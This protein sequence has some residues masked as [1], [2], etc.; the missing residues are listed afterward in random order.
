MK[1]EELLRKQLVGKKVLLKEVYEGKF[2]LY[3]KKSEM[4]QYEKLVGTIDWVYV[5]EHYPGYKICISVLYENTET[6]YTH[7]TPIELQKDEEIFFVES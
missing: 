7:N 5:E 2:L 6:G 4:Y 1:I 3:D